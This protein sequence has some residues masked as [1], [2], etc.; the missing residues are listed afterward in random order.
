MLPTFHAL[1][2]ILEH[3]DPHF[4]NSNFPF[5]FEIVYHFAAYAG[6]VISSFG[7]MKLQIA[8]VVDN[9]IVDGG[10]SRKEQP[11]GNI[12]RPVHFDQQQAERVQGPENARVKAPNRSRSSQ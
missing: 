1:P 9:G 12:V 5:L 10:S 2:W 11:T 4:W 8:L 7:P 3:R 6:G